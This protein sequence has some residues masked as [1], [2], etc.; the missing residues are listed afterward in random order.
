L[1]DLQL[2][3]QLGGYRTDRE[4]GEVG[5]TCAGLLFFGRERAIREVFPNYFLDYQERAS[6]DDPAQW[7]DRVTTDGTWSGNV[8]DFFRKVFP[9]LKADLK[10]PFALAVDLTRKDET[11]VGQ[12]LRE[13]LV[14]ALIHADYEGRT[15]IL[16]VKAREGFLL[17]NPGTL[18]LSIDEIR[19]GGRSDCRNRAL[20]RM[21]ARIGL[22]EQAGSGFAR[23]LRAWREQHWV[24][25]LIADDAAGDFSTLRLSVASLFPEGVVQRLQARYGR[26]FTGLDENGRLAVATAEA[27]GRVTNGRLQ[28]L[29]TAHPRDLTVLLRQLVSQGLLV[30]HGDRRGAWYSPRFASSG[31]VTGAVGV[32]TSSQSSPQSSPQSPP[33]SPSQT[34]PG[35]MSLDAT[36]LVAEVAGRS[37]APRDRVQAAILEV[38]RGRF[39][40][41]REI[42]TALERR[43]RTIVDNYLGELVTE[44]RLELREP[45]NPSSPNQAYRTVEGRP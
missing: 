19:A 37:W 16:V 32:L 13:A 18:R 28:S 2:L 26:R 3:E 29:T 35:S 17:R 12:A 6:L 45:S 24:V 33:Q 34:S 25:P 36:L 30:A 8:F 31:T 15:S 1:G 23:I 22:G 44:G 11:L 38:C 21:F 9:R 14:N 7:S 20:Q 4:S 39:V 43:V 27:E 40:T 10:V 42:A 5:L 41:A